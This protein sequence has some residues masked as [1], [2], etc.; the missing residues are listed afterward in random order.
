[1]IRKLL[2]SFASAALVFIAASCGSQMDT[3]G[4][5]TVESRTI[6]AEKATGNI[7]AEERIDGS[8]R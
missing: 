3:S 7:L 8:G 6:E 4:D 5:T 2:I 1:M